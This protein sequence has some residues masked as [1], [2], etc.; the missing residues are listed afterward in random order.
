MTTAI[1]TDQRFDLHTWHGHVEQAARLHAIRRAIEADG[2]L[3]HLVQLP[4]RPAT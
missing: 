3:P 4:I 2:L 1:L